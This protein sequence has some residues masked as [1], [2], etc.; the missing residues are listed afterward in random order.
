MSKNRD[1]DSLIRVIVNTVVHEIVIRHTN[2][3]ESVHFLNSEI[4]EY[5]G[6]VEKV[7]QK[8]TWNEEDREH[9]KDIAFKKIKERLAYKY[10]DVIYSE[11]EIKQL[12]GA[13]I[14]EMM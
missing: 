1:L 4:I 13:I 10:P 3:S 12:L 7:A 11:D 14:T 5:R 8:H 2:I 6:Q 9:V